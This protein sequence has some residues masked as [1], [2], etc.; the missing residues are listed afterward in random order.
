V[1]PG[2]YC[3]DFLRAGGAGGLWLPAVFGAVLHW[4]PDGARGYHHSAVG[5][6]Y[7]GVCGRA[8]GLQ[9]YPVP[10]RAGPPAVP[11]P[12]CPA[13]LEIIARSAGQRVPPPR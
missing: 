13:C 5:I 7:Y 1:S 3:D 2:R 9:P 8:S 11:S 6:A 4:V 12:Q 10:Q